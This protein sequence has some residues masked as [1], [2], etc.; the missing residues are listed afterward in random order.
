MRNVRVWF[1]KLGRAKYISHLDINRCMSRAV[2]RAG[3]PLW[4]TEGYH[5]H[6]YMTFSLPLPLGVESLCESMDIR[7]EED[8]FT[9]EMVQEK[10]DRVM[11]G[12]LSIQS[13]NDS[14]RKAKEIAY[15]D[16]LMTLAT[17]QQPGQTMECLRSAIESCQLLAEKKSKSGRKKIIKTINLYEFIRY[18]SLREGENGT[19]ELLMTLAA[20]PVKNVNPILMLDTILAKAQIEPAQTSILRRQ[21]FTEKMEIF[22]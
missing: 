2:R 18:Y 1:T 10:L 15:A 22:K 7:I 17:A 8:S 12:G 4:Y 19:V 6:P 5:P 9:N 11:P 16:Y 13:V 20:G 3:L 14:V 21:L